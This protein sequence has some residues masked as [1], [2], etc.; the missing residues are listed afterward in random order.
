[1]LGH[2]TGDLIWQFQQKK[3][4]LDKIPW[5]WMEREETRSDPEWSVF[6]STAPLVYQRSSWKL[7]PQLQPVPCQRKAVD[8]CWK[9]LWIRSYSWPSCAKNA[10]IVQI[11]HAFPRFPSLNSVSILGDVSLETPQCNGDTCLSCSDPDTTKPA[12]FLPWPTQRMAG[13]DGRWTMTKCTRKKKTPT[14]RT[15]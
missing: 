10:S 2:H 14:I 7:K 6:L 15:C 3:N 11:P 13:K 4:H 5:T 9:L 12:A 8:S 1:M